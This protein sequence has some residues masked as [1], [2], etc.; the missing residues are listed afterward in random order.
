MVNIFQDG[1]FIDF[2]KELFFA[3]VGATI[4]TPLFAFLVSRFSHSP[5]TIS[6]F[7]VLG[8]VFGSSAFWIGTRVY[9]R[10]KTKKYSVKHFANDILYFTPVAFLVSVLFY[11][12][13]IFFL[14]RHL[15]RLDHRVF[16]S[17][18]FSQ[19]VAFCFF[20]A[21]MNVYRYLLYI[22]TGKEL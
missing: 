5:S 19:L 12:P 2:N 11:Y 8:G 20:V 13:T 10:N 4:G 18:V 22:K 16:A 7:A 3:E 1:S 17:V 9:D 14:S 21:C 15:I 6:V